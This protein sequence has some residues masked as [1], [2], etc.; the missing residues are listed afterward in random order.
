METIYN[1]QDLDDY[2]ESNGSDEYIPLFEGK[3][4]FGLTTHLITT[5]SGSKMGKTAEGAV[6]LNKERLPP[7]EY[8]QFW[9]NTEDTM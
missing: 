9:R 2:Q 1:N 3:E 5:A 6:W 7:Y 8:W 4:L